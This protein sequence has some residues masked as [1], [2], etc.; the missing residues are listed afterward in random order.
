MN[1]LSKMKKT[2]KTELL[3]LNVRIEKD[4][5]KNIDKSIVT[6]KKKFPEFN[7]NL[8]NVVIAAL[9]YYIKQSQD[10]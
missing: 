2:K 9:E 5:K 1:I 3:Q 7:W 10:F 8:N 6:L 4:L